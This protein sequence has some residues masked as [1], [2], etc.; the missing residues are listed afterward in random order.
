MTAHH[1]LMDGR[2]HVY[3]RENS[4]YWQCSAFLKGKNWR[5]STKDDSLERA[6]DIAVDWYLEHAV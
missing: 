4:A 3:R 6:K 2:L 1:T 5:I